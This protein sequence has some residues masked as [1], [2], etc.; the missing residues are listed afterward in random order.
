M[1]RTPSQKALE[2]EE[3]ISR[4]RLALYKAKL[5]SR[6]GGNAIAQRR[7]LEAL[8]RSAAL[9]ARRVRDRRSAS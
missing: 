6:P 5:Y 3:R 8:E 2:D 9:A 7:R 1:S 4:L